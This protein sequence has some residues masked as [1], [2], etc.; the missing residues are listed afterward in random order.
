[1]NLSFIGNSSNVDSYHIHY[2]KL[3]TLLK[4]KGYEVNWQASLEDSI[5]DSINKIDKI[6]PYELTFVCFTDPITQNIEL[7]D[8][9]L[10][11]LKNHK[12]SYNHHIVLFTIHPKLYFDKEQSS[13]IYSPTNDAIYRLANMNNFNVIDLRDVLKEEHFNV[14]GEICETGVYAIVN[15]IFDYCEYCA[16][17]DGVYE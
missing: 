12:K 7:Y 17:Y 5:Y 3:P 1:M 6:N 2:L 16:E 9:F 13:S 8:E 4:Q 11:K 10:K 15:A 14:I